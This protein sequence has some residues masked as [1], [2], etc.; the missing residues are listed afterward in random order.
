MLNDNPMRKFIQL[1]LILFLAALLSNSRLETPAASTSWQ[2][3]VD[4]LILKSANPEETEFL[5]FL[6]EQA[7]LTGAKEFGTKDKKVAY[8][9][10][11][12][13]SLAEHTQDRSWMRWRQGE[14]S[15]GRSGSQ[16]WFGR[17]A[18]SKMWRQ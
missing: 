2:D 1:S 5:I 18:P 9:Y 15:T 16:T 14:S 8:V 10:Q 11:Q 6:D 7:D 17:A 12:L 4:K 13:N 3:K